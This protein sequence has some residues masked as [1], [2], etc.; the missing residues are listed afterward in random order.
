M[1]PIKVLQS[2]YENG[3]AL[4]F[5]DV[6]LSTQYSEVFPKDT[7]LESR[8]STNIPLKIPMVSAAMDTVTERQMA[9]NL[10]MLGGLGIIH[11]NMSADQQAKE[12]SRVK[13][14]LSGKI[15][16][17][18]C[19]SGDN[20]VSKVLEMRDKKA[21]T[22]HSF[23]VLDSGARLTGI[24]T[25]TDFEFCDDN[26]LSVSSIMT[27]DP[28]TAPEGTTVDQAYTIM[29]ENRKKLLPLVDKGNRVKGLYVFSDVKR[30]KSGHADMYNLDQKGR[31]RVGAAIGIGSEG[32]SRAQKLS[33]ENVD[34]FVI[35]TAHADTKSVLETVKF[36]KEQF[37]STDLVVGNVSNGES[38]LHLAELGVNGIKV[39]QG[40]G[41]ICTT[42]VVAGVGTPQVSAI[43]ECALAVEN[44]DIPI[45]ADGG[46]RSSGDIT[47]AIAAGAHNVMM[48]GMLAGTNEAPGELIFLDG[49]QWKTYRGMGSLGA[50]RDHKESRDRYLQPA[51]E[52]LVPEGI[53]GRVAYKGS[54]AQVIHQYTGGLRSGMGYV[55]ANSIKDLR[56]KAE[57]RRV[58][59]AGKTESHPHDV[60]ITKDAP[61]YSGRT[62]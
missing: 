47:K 35:D 13:H 56:E 52:K 40:P 31:L 7:I 4:T 16:K 39:G 62:V 36:L 19:V 26:S 17:P 42:R 38:A 44:Y 49:R 33:K 57:F 10:A 21:Y 58:S 18:I 25:E 15:E 29:K 20:L 34:V 32:F 23:P 9:I 48:G 6:T 1:L 28:L 12:V 41:G 22:F 54:L 11:K 27:K 60:H 55:G 46:L 59:P 14:Y 61:N 5:D 43:Y 53:E 45:C 8:F 3:E 37:V 2:A 24:V 51:K 30:T 50:M